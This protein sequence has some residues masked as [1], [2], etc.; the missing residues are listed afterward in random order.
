VNIL[1]LLPSY[2]I[3]ARPVSASNSISCAGRSLVS[4]VS[5]FRIA[6]SL[7]LIL[8]LLAVPAQT[9]AES[10]QPASAA[11]PEQE[12]EQL[13]RAL[14]DKGT[15]G[16]Y[17]RLKSFAQS[18]S[19]GLLGKRAAL[20]LGYVDYS[21]GHYPQALRWLRIAEDDLVLR[22]YALYWGAMTERAM[23]NNA[24]ALVQLNVLHHDFPGSVM[25][26]QI[27][28]ALGETALAVQKPEQGLAALDPDP[29]V[30]SKPALLLLRGQLREQA[31]RLDGAAA[32]YQAVYY[33]LPLTPQA[34]EAGNK[35][36]LL[37]VK[38]GE[39][40]PK[41]TLEEKKS[42]AQVLYDAHRW[43]EAN[44]DYSRLLNQFT[45]SD[46]ELA[47]LRM[48]QCRVGLGAG[49]DSFTTLTPSDAEVDAERLYSLSQ[50]YRSQKREPEMLAAVEQTAARSPKSR[51]TEQA[52]FSTGNYYWVQLDLDRAGQFYRRVLQDFPGGATTVIADWRVA[53][54]AYRQRQPQAASL[55]EE[56]IRQH[57]GSTYIADALYWLGRIAERSGNVP[58]ARAYFTKLADRYPQNYFGARAVE[59]L[60]AIGPGLTDTV[61]ILSQIPLLPAAPPLDEDVPPA[62]AA[63][64]DR[65]IALHSIAFDASAEMEFR[66]AYIATGAPSLLLEAAQEAVEA[67]RYGVA[68][69][70]IRQIVSQLESRP[71][72]Q[73]SWA[74][75][76]VAYPL[77]YRVELERSAARAG[78][79]PMQVAGLIRQE[80][81]FQPEAYS[82]AGAM[83]LM[84]LIPSTAKKMAKQ[85][86]VRFSRPRLFEPEYNL[87]LGTIYLAGLKSSYG[88][89]EAALAAYNAGED[90]VAAWE[91]GRT[92]DEPAEFVDSIPFTETREYVQVVMRNGAIYREVYGPESFRHEVSGKVADRQTASEPRTSA[93]FPRRWRR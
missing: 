29:S 4:P 84:Q 62:A 53:W 33:Q 26:E 31:G 6:L 47:L 78:V 40:F 75:W 65:A 11:S 86:K 59:R 55:L 88:S 14:H 27:L 12:L 64:R 15:A 10:K 5:H 69:V 72:S 79:D 74:V 58:L 44:E 7:V 57:P 8:A 3:E 54:Q 18:R 68:F 37:A 23:N 85:V 81:A 66:A 22:E 51:W 89:L 70:T 20:A 87:R 76:R 13:A 93:S 16:A 9:F 34:T 80:S 1:I 32:D 82:H 42:R 24:G 56:H 46:H 36:S 77:P 92:Y 2:D 17:D 50:V 71:F 45:G 39:K 21:K 35:L 73:V 19:S 28:Q 38:L 30:S 49:A 67:R 52:L 41:V 61:A 90:R 60:R 25:N 48:A 91:A 63:R 83:G 43:R